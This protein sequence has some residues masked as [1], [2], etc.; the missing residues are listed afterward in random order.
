MD[1]PIRLMIMVRGLNS[2]TVLIASEFSIRS[3]HKKE[4]N[5]YSVVTRQKTSEMNYIYINDKWVSSLFD[6]RT[7]VQIAGMI[8]TFL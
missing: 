8:I 2:F 5:I 4:H 1:L 7:E 3:L 6:I